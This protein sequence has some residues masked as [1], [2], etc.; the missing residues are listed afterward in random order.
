MSSSSSVQ[1]RMCLA[2][3]GEMWSGGNSTASKL[4]LSPDAA[5]AIAARAYAAAAVQ[6]S[7]PDARKTAA[8]QK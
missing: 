1:L 5:A 2:E 7:E 6:P 3:F 8:Q 4:A